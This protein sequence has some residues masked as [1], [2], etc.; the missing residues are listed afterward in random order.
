[1]AT[2]SV[3]RIVQ[4]VA[5]RLWTGPYGG[6]E[7]FYYTTV[8]QI[9]SYFE[10]LNCLIVNAYNDRKIEPQVMRH[11]DCST[12]QA[13]FECA[14]KFRAAFEARQLPE[15]FMIATSFGVAAQKLWKLKA[16]VRRYSRLARAATP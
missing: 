9:V 16:S 7:E 12:K 5:R 2:L 15:N 1:M 6:L 3:E 11:F 14:R 13:T 10:P 4:I 8:M